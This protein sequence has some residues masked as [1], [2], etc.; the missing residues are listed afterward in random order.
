MGTSVSV[1]KKCRHFRERSKPELFKANELQMPGVLKAKLEWD[2]Q[3]QERRLIELQRFEA[4]QPFNYEPHHYPWCAA[5]TPYDNTLPDLIKKVLM[6]EDCER[7]RD[8]IGISIECC[9]DENWIKLIE[10]AISGDNAS[11]KELTINL[12]GISHARGNSLIKLAE[13]G[14]D[15]ALQE[16][17]EKGR[18]TVNP[19]TGEIMQIYAL[20]ARMNPRQQCPV[21][22]PKKNN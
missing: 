22:E 19:V 18:A 17:A 15:E 6:E 21:F 13:A 12:A 2:Q 20:C 4:D 5:Y 8:L 10:R 14:D 11:L 16:L 7:I 9:I 3:E 1:C